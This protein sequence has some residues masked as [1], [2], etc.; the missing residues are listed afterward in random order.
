MT[1]LCDEN[2]LFVPT[3]IFVPNH[4]YFNSKAL[5]FYVVPTVL[6]R[7]YL[8]SRGRMVNPFGE[9]NLHVVSSRFLHFCVLIFIW[10]WNLVTGLVI[11]VVICNLLLTDVVHILCSFSIDIIRKKSACFAAENLKLRAIWDIT[12]LYC[13]T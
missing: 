7:K 5:K 1:F 2:K 4:V 8:C 10:I 13:L 9:K 12:M 3:I 11:L 6:L